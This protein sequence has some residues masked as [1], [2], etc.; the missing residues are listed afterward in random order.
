[1]VYL[2]QGSCC[3]WSAVRAY[4]H[5]LEQLLVLRVFSCALPLTELTHPLNA[6]TY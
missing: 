2:E 6:L 3:L 4:S 1:M 5:R